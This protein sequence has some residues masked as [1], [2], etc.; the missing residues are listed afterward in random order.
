MHFPLS[1]YRNSR[2]T[3]ESQVVSSV[4]GKPRCGCSATQVPSV[5]GGEGRC[6]VA[7]DSSYVCFVRSARVGFH[8]PALPASPGGFLLCLQFCPSSPPS[9]SSSSPLAERP[10]SRAAT[11]PFPLLL[12]SQSL[13]NLLKALPV[14]QVRKNFYEVSALFFHYWGRKDEKYKAAVDF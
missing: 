10:S 7:A 4:P 14:F 6:G 12:H 1:L 13:E 3:P 2:G 9:S 11:P 8:A 5:A